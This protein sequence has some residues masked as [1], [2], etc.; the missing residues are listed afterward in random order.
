[1]SLSRSH[2]PRA[3]E[4][5]RTGTPAEGEREGRSE[6]KEGKMDGET[7][8]VKPQGELHECGWDVG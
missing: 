8:E 7:Q 4:K 1:M 3:Q 5:S 6:G 2:S